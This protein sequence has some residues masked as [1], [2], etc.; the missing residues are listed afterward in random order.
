MASPLFTSLLGML[1]LIALCELVYSQRANFG[2]MAHA[3]FAFRKGALLSHPSAPEL[4]QSCLQPSM[5]PS[6]NTVSSFPQP[7]MCAI[8][9]TNNVVVAWNNKWVSIV[10]IT[11]T[12]G[13]GYCNDY[14]QCLPSNGDRP[15]IDGCNC[16]IWITDLRRCTE[17]LCAEY[18]GCQECSTK[19]Y[20]VW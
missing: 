15:G 5:S 20:C 7:M 13:C 16:D 3:Q 9:S 2:Q 4:N 11:D 12:K 1:M 17:G 6:Y 14:D 8:Y 18:N 19:P 10:G